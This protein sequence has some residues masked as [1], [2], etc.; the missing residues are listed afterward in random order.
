MTLADFQGIHAGT[1]AYIVGKGPTLDRIEAA[2][3]QLN[4]C[5]NVIMALNEAIHKIEALNLTVPLY[6]VQQDCKL[7][8]DC[9]PDNPNTVHF[10]NSWQY[11]PDNKRSRRVPISAFDPNAVLYNYP[12]TD[13]SAVAALKLAKHMGC[14]KV[15]FVAFDSWV[16]EKI[17]QYAA[18]IN[19]D[20]GAVGDPA[21]H[22]VNGAWI[23]EVARDLFGMGASQI[24]LLLI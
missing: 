1:T 4:V 20:S 13:L 8:F 15:A 6:C 11:T 5:G 9:V 10:M 14:V 23:R 7:E 3:D 24:P 18:C 2:R 16:D 17:G 21:R 12:E 19:K 22:S